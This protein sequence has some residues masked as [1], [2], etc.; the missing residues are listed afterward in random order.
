MAGTPGAGGWWVPHVILGKFQHCEECPQCPRQSLRRGSVTSSE[1][2]P[3]PGVSSG[4]HTGDHAA[5]RSEPPYLQPQTG[6][7]TCPSAIAQVLRVDSVACHIVE[8]GSHHRLRGGVTKS[9][10]ELPPALAESG[11]TEEPTGSGNGGLWGVGP[12]S[13]QGLLVSWFLDLD[14]SDKML[15]VYENSLNTYLRRVHFSVCVRR[16]N[17]KLYKT[18]QNPS[19]TPP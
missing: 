18:P 19:L 10:A 4:T 9:Q 13:P 17:Q 7:P 8:S 5:D 14:A 1:H 15:L 11:R 6:K 12:R 3:S 16:F 2:S